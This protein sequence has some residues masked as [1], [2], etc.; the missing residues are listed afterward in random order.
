MPN[1]QLALPQQFGRFLLNGALVFTLLFWGMSS[2]LISTHDVHRDLFSIRAILKGCTLQS[3]A[4]W[5]RDLEAA[6]VP[7]FFRQRPLLACYLIAAPLA[8]LAA[9]LYD[10]KILR[11]ENI[12]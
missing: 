9:F 6:F 2:I 11:K 3:F 7:F 1:P 4:A 5:L 12:L 10:K 8:W